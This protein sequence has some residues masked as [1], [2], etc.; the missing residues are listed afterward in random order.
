MLTIILIII[1]YSSLLFALTTLLQIA[2]YSHNR[3]VLGYA[4]WLEI[5]G[6]NKVSKSRLKTLKLKSS[7]T[8]V[9]SIVMLILLIIYIRENRSL[10][11]TCLIGIILITISFIIVHSEM[12]SIKNSKYQSTADKWNTPH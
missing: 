3:N 9:I 1:T 12:K 4:R 5:S 10:L 11:I 2:L 6:K 8:S 7:A